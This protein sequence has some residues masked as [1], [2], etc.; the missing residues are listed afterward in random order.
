MP[1]AAQGCPSIFVCLVLQP[2]S[3]LP[4]QSCSMWWAPSAPWPPRL[5]PTLSFCFLFQRL[6]VKPCA[7]RQPCLDQ[8]VS[9]TTEKKH[10][11]CV[12]VSC[13]WLGPTCLVWCRTSLPSSLIGRNVL[14]FL[15]VVLLSLWLLAAFCSVPLYPLGPHSCT[16]LLSLCPESWCSLPSQ[17]PGQQG[18]R[19]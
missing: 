5:R 7:H 15:R 3:C 11:N 17:M 14:E 13:I 19:R 6:H 12:C 18:R 8:H 16:Y 4:P 2:E 1:K 10:D 9:V